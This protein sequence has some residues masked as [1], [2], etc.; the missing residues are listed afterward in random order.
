MENSRAFDSLR[1][2]FSGLSFLLKTIRSDGPSP[3]RIDHAP[4]PPSDEGSAAIIKN[5]LTSINIIILNNL[6]HDNMHL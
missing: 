2:L 4:C 6:N 1:V 5:I 3:L